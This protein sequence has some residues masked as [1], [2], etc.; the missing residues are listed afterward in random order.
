MSPLAKAVIS[1]NIKKAENGSLSFDMA[2]LSL[3]K[4]AEKKSSAKIMVS[5]V[6]PSFETRTLLEKSSDIFLQLTE[7]CEAR[8]R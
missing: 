5:S 6:P 2:I 8:G 1:V 4:L 7:S 3:D